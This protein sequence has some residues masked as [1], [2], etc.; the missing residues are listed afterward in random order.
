MRL[1]NIK[2]SKSNSISCLSKCI[3]MIISE[4]NDFEINQ[5]FNEI[6]NLTNSIDNNI[7]TSDYFDKYLKCMDESIDKDKSLNKKLENKF[8][9]RGENSNYPLLPSIYRKNN[10]NKYIYKKE[11]FLFYE[12]LVRRPEYFKNTTNFEKIVIMQHYCCPTRLLDITTNP[13]IALYFACKGSIDHKGYLYI[14]NF[15]NST[16]YEYSDK[17][18]I[19]SCLPKFSYDHL[20]SDNLDRKTFPKLRNGKYAD[21]LVERFYHEITLEK[22]TL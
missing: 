4:T 19:L 17:V 3:D 16:N 21:N 6:N 11:S 20:A 15:P 22:T 13:L 2:E 12:M 8:Y 10:F 14:F 18:S 7:K 1:L 5:I 9:Y